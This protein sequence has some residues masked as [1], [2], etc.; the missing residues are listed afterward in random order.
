MKTL[1]AEY[2]TAVAHYYTLVRAAAAAA[3]PAHG[4]LTV[5]EE[6]N[7][8]FARDDAQAAYKAMQS[9]RSPE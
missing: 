8:Q 3:G 6:L 2:N 9:A 4:H 5:D 7:I 1:I